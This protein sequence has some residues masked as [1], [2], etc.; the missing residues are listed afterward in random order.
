MSTIMHCPRRRETKRQKA[1]GNV[2]SSNRKGDTNDPRTL[3]K[4]V[5]G[6]EREHGEMPERYGRRDKSKNNLAAPRLTPVSW[7]TERQICAGGNG[8]KVDVLLRQGGRS[9][10]E[11]D[12]RGVFE[13]LPGHRVS[14]PP[15]PQ[16]QRCL[17][18]R[19]PR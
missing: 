2:I 1:A 19:G 14:E 16:R 8:R 11:Q 17:Q 12:I 10:S 18:N 13:P 3:E 4:S 15:L 5:T 7:G 6:E 9:G